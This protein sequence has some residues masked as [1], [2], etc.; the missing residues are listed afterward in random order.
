MV[1]HVLVGRLEL[2]QPPLHVV[3]DEDERHLLLAELAAEQVHGVQEVLRPQLALWVG[4]GEDEDEQANTKKA[5]NFP[6]KFT[7]IVYN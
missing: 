1:S 5:P 6:F 3:A 7:H 4:V 2:P